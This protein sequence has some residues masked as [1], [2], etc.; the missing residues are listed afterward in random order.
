MHKKVGSPTS[1][2]AILNVVQ[3]HSTPSNVE[4]PSKKGSN[5]SGFD[6]TQPVTVSSST[7]L[8]GWS[9]AVETLLKKYGREDIAYSRARGRILES[10]ATVDRLATESGSTVEERS[11][12][13][14]D[15]DARRQVFLLEGLLKM[16][17][18]ALGKK[19]AKKLLA[20]VKELEDNLGASVMYPSILKQAQA[21]G[22][23][24]AVIQVLE[25]DQRKQDQRLKSV[26]A[27]GWMPDGAGRIET[28][29]KVIKEI[30]KADFGSYD[31]DRSFFLKKI[32]KELRDV[33]H[34]TYDLTQPDAGIHEFRRDVR[35]I[36]VYVEAGNGLIQLSE[37]FNPI[38]QFEPLLKGET[39]HSK[40]VRL[41]PVG[42]EAR[43][44]EVSKSM[45]TAMMDTVLGLGAIKDKYEPL[46]HLAKIYVQLGLA[47]DYKHAVKELD[48]KLLAA[49]DA[50]DF[51]KQAKRIYDSLKDVKFFETMARE[52]E[53]AAENS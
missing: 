36:P 35:W 3:D 33:D 31:A 2:T 19:D 4:K 20:A 32:A 38:E 40:F 43:P 11:A 48:P 16:Y 22:L 46:D 25:H 51:Q 6:G 34:T 50:K 39:A 42:S 23:P 27:S 30:G 29:D 14:I 45:Y 9:P 13:L 41:P 52:Y 5:V 37:K 53:R 10:V 7:G 44:A 1:T 28:L 49:E 17:D 18:D 21:A 24:H 47:K 15:H 8:H 26:V 12:K